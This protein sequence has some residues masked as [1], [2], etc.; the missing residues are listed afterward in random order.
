M[1]LL[2]ELVTT[3]NLVEAKRKAERKPAINNLVAKHSQNSAGVHQDN[4]GEG[5]K[6]ATKN[7]IKRK[8][9]IVLISL[10]PF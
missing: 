6:C 9:S 1:S 3:I 7:T 2:K 4:V 8:S 10:P 5:Q